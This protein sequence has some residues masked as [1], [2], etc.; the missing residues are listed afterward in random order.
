MFNNNKVTPKGLRAK[1]ASVRKQVIEHIEN[2]EFDEA[3]TKSTLADQLD[4]LLISI[5]AN[6][7]IEG[8]NV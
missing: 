8:E 7:A 2:E 6:D 5:L 3:N 1:I 4:E